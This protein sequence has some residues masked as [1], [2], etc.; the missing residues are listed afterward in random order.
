MNNTTPD[1]A[2][3]TL[4][5]LLACPR[6]DKPLKRRDAASATARTDRGERGGAGD[7]GV[8]AYHC[9]GCR[10]DFPIVA[11][12]PCLYADPGSALAEWRLRFARE[13]QT[14]A[15]QSRQLRQAL[16]ALGTDRTAPASSRARIERLLHAR[17]QTAGQVRELLGPFAP[18]GDDADE[19]PALATLIALRTRLPPSQG[20]MT[21]EANVFR[22]WTPWG[23]EENALSLA[24]LTPH[25]PADIGSMLVLGCGAGR[26]AFDLHAHSGAT[27]TVGL[28][29]N[30]MLARVATLAADG[31][32]RTLHEFPLAPRTLRDVAV[33]RTLSAPNR[34]RPGLTFA[35][36]DV[37]R[38]PFRSGAAD[39][40]ITPW[41]VDILDEDFAVT[42]ARVNQLLRP[43]G[44][45]VCFGSLSFGGPDALKRY[46]L[47][48]VC[49]LMG[50]TGFDGPDVSEVTLPY[51]RSSASRHSRIEQVVVLAGRR[52]RGVKRPARH[53]A[54]P[55]W[56]TTGRSPVPLPESFQ[57]QAASTR[58]HAFL[59]SMIDGKRTVQDMA[60]L[61]EAQ[62]LMPRAEAEV[63]IR[64][65]L[66]KMFDESQ[67]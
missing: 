17:E 43:G 61:M 66:I 34:A 67:A 1:E 28:D 16:K 14:S 3:M 62:R 21:Y 52:V 19:A 38:P 5:E 20:L 23:D 59:M 22:D 58:I 54:L 29:I 24:A 44:V 27:R 18:H 41:L 12:I 47:E 64:G 53:E 15:Q 42:A 63:A 51:L 49:E 60:A 4:D 36:G 7:D 33:E 57:L 48:E 9:S 25:L 40:V 65:F 35:L 26:L 2:A 30:P 55:D 6:C 31:Q 50:Q 32:L 10:V 11:G 45:W 13:Q 37:R 56:I 39:V 46:S 8:P